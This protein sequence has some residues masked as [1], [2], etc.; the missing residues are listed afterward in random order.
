MKPD[1]WINYAVTLI[2][3]L[4]GYSLKF[5][6]W[7]ILYTLS[8]TSI[9]SDPIFNDLFYDSNPFICKLSS[10]YVILMLN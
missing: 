10:Q 3:Y 6:S 9:I 5:I 2:V 8:L 7:S 4:L 1:S